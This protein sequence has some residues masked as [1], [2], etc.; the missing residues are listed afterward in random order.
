MIRTMI[1]LMLKGVNPKNPSR[2]KGGPLEKV[3]RKRVYK[4]EASLLT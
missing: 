3:I 2:V 4:K 1:R